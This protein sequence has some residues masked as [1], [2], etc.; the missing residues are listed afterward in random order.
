MKTG[1]LM[2]KQSISIDQKDNFWPEQQ[3]A[4]RSRRGLLELDLILVPFYEQSYHSLDKKS[5]RQHQWLLDQKDPSLQQWLVYRE[6]TSSLK[7]ECLKA[8]KRIWQFVD[9]NITR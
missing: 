6:S 3:V 4:W 9:C 2:D 8:V 1:L 7:D 5:Q